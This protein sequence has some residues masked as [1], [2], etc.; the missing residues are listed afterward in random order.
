MGY[1]YRYLIYGL[2]V[3]SELVIP[4]AAICK[5]S[6]GEVCTDVEI[7]FGEMPEKIRDFATKGYGCWI[8]RFRAAWFDTR[9]TAQY[10]V[11]EGNKIVISPHQNPDEKLM[12]SMI[13]SAGMSLILLQRN[14]PV[15]HGSVIVK[16]G[17]AY[18]IS[19]NSGAGKSTITMELLKDE[20]VLFM[21]DD[22]VRLTMEND[23]IYC[24]PTYPQQK[25][26][27]DLACR[28]GLDLSKLVYIDEGRDKFAL[29]RTDRYYD[30]KVPLKGVFVLDKEK[31]AKGVE[32]EELHGIEY[33]YS[34]ID[35]LYL[36][37]E[38]KNIL[39]I[40]S[41]IMDLINKLY[42]QAK[43]YKVFRPEEG[44]TVKMVADKI[45][46]LQCC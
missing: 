36:A 41:E 18:I 32:Y 21:A 35:N 17:C 9:G 11:T 26:C 27:R 38:Y 44:D 5:D 34:F 20:R 24:H 12:I 30:K 6:A 15:L 25:V 1:K 8:N 37:D 42:Y 23:I 13:L 31:S 45:R 46:F 40:P 39:G 10:L 7:V 3:E 22:T 28:M 33:V 14:D 19:G 16:N 4:Q 29:K 2:V 43:I